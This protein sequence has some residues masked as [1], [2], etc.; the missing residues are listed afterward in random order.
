MP[1]KRK[2]RAANC[3]S[4]AVKGSVANF[5]NGRVGSRKMAWFSPPANRT[6]AL[7]AICLRH[8]ADLCGSCA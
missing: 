3:E 5:L 1:G 2:A 8:V 6:A 7:D 4:L